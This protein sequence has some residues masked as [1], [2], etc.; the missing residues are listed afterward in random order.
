MQ[1]VRPDVVRVE[2]QLYE[3]DTGA[4]VR[5]PP[6]D[7]SYRTIA[8]PPVLAAMLREQIGRSRPKACACHGFTYAFSGHREANGAAPAPGPKLVDVARLAGV[9]TGTVSNVL[10]QR[11]IVTD[12]TWAA[13]GSAIAELG[14]VRGARSGELASHWRRSGFATWLFKPA[15][16]GWHPASAPALPRPVPLLGEPWPGIPLRG[17]DASGRATACWA[18]IAPGLTPH[19]LRHSY[20]TLMVQLGTPPV[21]MDEHMGHED[22]SIGARYS[23]VT[24][25]MVRRLL[26]GLTEVW[27]DALVERRRMAPGSPVAVL[28]RMLREGR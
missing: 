7:D 19:G 22:G 6:K 28:D 24:K 27:E 16:T 25:E 15:A 17:R 5:C 3:L 1:F 21:V 13:V 14:Y 20:K 8:V 11:S 26:E 9:S 23:H 10:N 4:L 12:V 2:W 18:P